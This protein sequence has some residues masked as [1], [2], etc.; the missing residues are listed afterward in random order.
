[1][2][3]IPSNYFTLPG[4]GG[5]GCLVKDQISILYLHAF[6]V[7]K[8]FLFSIW[9]CKTSL[10]SGVR[11]GD[12][13][14]GAAGEEAA[15]ALHQA[16]RTSPAPCILSHGVSTLGIAAYLGHWVNYNYISVS[17]A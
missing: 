13:A 3:F 6:T 11:G 7:Y 10:R 2:N 16:E 15:A 1:M 5:L 14:T 8:L 17:P 4:L 9:L 12:D